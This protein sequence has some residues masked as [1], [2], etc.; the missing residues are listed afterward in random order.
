M[1]VSDI[2]YLPKCLDDSVINSIIKIIKQSGLKEKIEYRIFAD[3]DNGGFFI[4]YLY[5]N[6]FRLRGNKIFY[7][8]Q[9]DIDDYYKDFF[10]D[11]DNY[12]KIDLKAS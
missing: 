10:V 9:T 4:N 11:F 12:I 8:Y 6:K 2:I 5:L 1:E 3:A 7:I